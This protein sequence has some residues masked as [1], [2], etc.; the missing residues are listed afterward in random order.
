MSNKEN[1]EKGEDSASGILKEASEC[2]NDRAQERDNVQERSMRRCVDGF[3]GLTGHELTE[4]QGWLFMAT[5]KM[6]R[7]T[8][9]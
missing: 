1:S 2:I 6:A 8:W 7:L 5:L 9:L 3:N 4:E